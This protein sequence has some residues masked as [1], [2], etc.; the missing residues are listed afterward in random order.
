MDARQY[1]LKA[2][3]WIRVKG[4]RFQA[5]SFNDNTLRAIRRSD[6]WDDT[7]NPEG[8]EVSDEAIAIE[9]LSSGSLWQVPVSVLLNNN[10]NAIQ[11][12]SWERVQP[13]QGAEDGFSVH[14]WLIKSCRWAKKV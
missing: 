7:D 9:E 11:V 10:L 12:K 2:M 14:A 13:G 1:A 3:G 8:L 6:I 4:D 5:W